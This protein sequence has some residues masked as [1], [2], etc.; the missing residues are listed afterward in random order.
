[1][2]RLAFLSRAFG[3]EARIITRTE[4]LHQ[5]LEV[6]IA[7]AE[8][9]TFADSE[10]LRVEIRA[11]V[12][13]NDRQA[14]HLEQRLSDL[15]EA[16]TSHLAKLEEQVQGVAN[17][18]SNEVLLV[19]RIGGRPFR[20]FVGED[21][22][23]RAKLADR[24][25]LAQPPVVVVSIPK[26]GTYLIG[27][28]LERLGYQDSELHVSQ[29]FLT[30]YRQLSI[31][32]KRSKASDHVFHL[33]IGASAALVDDGQFVVGHLHAENYAHT[34]LRGFRKIFLYRNLVDATLSHMRFLIDTGRA[35]TDV[36]WARMP[37]SPRQALAFLADMGEE[38]FQRNYFPVMGWLDDPEVFALPFEILAGGGDEAERSTRLAALAAFLDTKADLPSLLAAEV[39]GKPT[40]TL[41][42]GRT[43]AEIYLDDMVRQ[44]FRDLGV[45]AGHERLGYPPI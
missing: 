21:R 28:L 30:D 37:P 39:L 45:N 4:Q 27:L 22:R 24:R 10:A 31:A 36:A 32:D 34:A 17:A 33:S 35:P 15:G 11:S 3:G 5:D 40:K 42:A 7:A 13:R 8:A 20:A 19:D 23:L 1:M 16:L 41:S 9:R 6:R 12:E 43:K 29:T 2:K 44:A 26:S 25:R 14:D 18:Q 38:L